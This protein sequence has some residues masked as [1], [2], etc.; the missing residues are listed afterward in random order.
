MTKRACELHQ[1]LQRKGPLAQYKKD[2]SKLIILSAFSS[3]SLRVVVWC[4]I[5]KE[6]TGYG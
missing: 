6:V 2:V 4:A 5:A 3:Y 1:F